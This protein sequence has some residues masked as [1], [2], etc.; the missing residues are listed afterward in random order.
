MPDNNRFDFEVDVRGTQR[1]KAEIVGL[2]EQTIAKASEA[3]RTLNQLKT[4]SIEHA[5]SV[6]RQSNAVREL[7]IVRAR[8]VQSIRDVQQA[9]TPYLQQV[10]QL[11]KGLKNTEGLLK[12]TTAERVKLQATIGADTKKIAELTSKEKLYQSTIAATKDVLGEN[13][14]ILSKLDALKAQ[15]VNNSRILSSQIVTERAALSQLTDAQQKN[16]V[17]KQKAQQTYQVFEGQVRNLKKEL[18]EYEKGQ[19]ASQRETERMTESTL[20]LANAVGYAA[21]NAFRRVIEAIKDFL[22]EATIYAARTDEMRLAMLNMSKQSGVSRGELLRQAEAMQRMNI[23]TQETYE[24]LT[25]FQLAQLDVGKATQLARVAQDLAVVAG[26]ETGEEVNRLVHGITTLQ[27]RVLRTAGVYLSL[28]QTYQEVARATGRSTESF[29]EAE[30]QQIALNKVIELGQRAAGNYETALDNAGKRMRSMTRLFQD[31]ENAVGGLLQGPFGNLVDALST[32]LSLIANYPR[33]FAAAVVVLAAFG[34]QLLKTSAAMGGMTARVFQ[35]AAGLVTATKAT[36]GLAQATTANAAAMNGAAVAGTTWRGA[37][38]NIGTQAGILI[39]LMA[40]LDLA[41]AGVAETGKLFGKTTKF[42]DV[43]DP[44]DIKVQRDALVEMRREQEELK[45]LLDERQKIGVADK[46][47]RGSG[48]IGAGQRIIDVGAKYLPLLQGAQSL[49]PSSRSTEEL[50]KRYRELTDDIEKASVAVGEQKDEMSLAAALQREYA[51][52]VGKAGRAHLDFSGTSE[53]V[54][55]RLDRMRNQLKAL[56][57]PI[58][59]ET[60][61][62]LTFTERLQVLKPELLDLDTIFQQSATS[63]EDY[64]Q[65]LANAEA[66]MP[67]FTEAVRRLRTEGEKLI[68]GVGEREAEAIRRLIDVQRRLASARREIIS[69][70]G[71]ANDPQTRQTAFLETE[72]KRLQI[73]R[74]EIDSI[75]SARINLNRDIGKPIPTS[76]E[77][78]LDLQSTY[79]T[80]IKVRD[81]IRTAQRANRDF[82]A[83]V[84]KAQ[85]IASKAR[86]TAITA[87]L[88]A[89]KMIA[90]NQTKRIQD[91]RQ[92]TAEIIALSKERAE[93]ARDEAGTSR[94]AYASFYKEQ[95]ENL[96]TLEDTN[97]RLQ[98]QLEFLGGRKI[99]GLDIPQFEN[100]STALEDIAIPTATQAENVATITQSVQNIEKSVAANNPNYVTGLGGVDAKTLAAISPGAKGAPLLSGNVADA[101]KKYGIDPNLLL[102]LAYRE[103]GISQYNDRGGVL[104]SSAGALGVMQLMP[105]T[106]K[107][108]GADPYKT[109]ENIDAGA[110]YLS[111]LIKMFNGKLNLALAGYNAGEFVKNAPGGGT[112]AQ[113]EA[114]LN[115]LLAKNED[116]QNYVKSILGYTGLEFPQTSPTLARGV[117]GTAFQQKGVETVVPLTP[118]QIMARTRLNLTI[119]ERTNRELQTQYAGSRLSDLGVAGL[120]LETGK[121]ELENYQKTADELRLINQRIAND[122]YDSETHKQQVTTAAELVRR[123]AVLVTHDVLLA[124]IDEEQ[125]QWRDSEEY[126]INIAE[127]AEAKIRQAYNNS[128]DA[129]ESALAERAKREEF[130]DKYL[131]TIHQQAETNRIRISLDAEERYD[132]MLEESNSKFRE[133]TEFKLAQWKNFEVDRFNE[134]KRAEDNIAELQY[135]IQHAT[136]LDPLVIEE[137]RLKAILEVQQAD[138]Q[139]KASMAANAVK[140]ADAQVYHADRANAKIL[141]Y[142]AQQETLDDVVANIR[143]GTIDLAFNTLDTAIGKLTAKLGIF[144]ELVKSII[145][146]FL[147]LSL[148]KVFQTLFGLQTVSAQPAQQNVGGGLG[149]II[150]NVLGGITGGRG[151]GPTGIFGT[152]PPFVP[153]ASGPFGLGGIIGPQQGTQQAL[154]QIF[155]GITGAPVPTFPATAERTGGTWGDFGRVLG[156]PG[157]GGQQRGGIFSQLGGAFGSIAPMFPFLGAALGAQLGGGSKLGSVLGTAGGALG[158][159]LGIALA[160]TSIGGLGGLAAGLAPLGIVAAVA[161]PLLIAGAIIASRNKKRRENETKRDAFTTDALGQLNQ[162]LSRVRRDQIS[163]EEALAQATSIRAQYIQQSQALTDSKTRGIALKD[164]SRLDLVIGQIKAASKAQERRRELDAQLVPEFA[165]GGLVSSGVGGVVPGRDLGYDNVLALLRP[166]EVVLNTRQQQAIGGPTAL[167]AAGVPGFV[168][169]TAIAARRYAEGGYSSPFV[170]SSFG[171]SRGKQEQDINVYIVTNKKYAE[172]M[173]EQG[174]D[175][176]IELADN[177]IRNKGRIYSAGK[178]NF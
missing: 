77:E 127:D 123:K 119:Q 116:V 7:S 154:Q 49:F 174:R 44:N 135:Q 52:Q 106:A 164:V 95:L 166:N 158:G 171:L 122:F 78:R 88:T 114:R 130:H 173:A 20:A 134:T 87:E 118:G 83:E 43:L 65:K 177:D 136:D 71:L 9:S 108:F 91:E 5:N 105:G 157:G 42:S 36:L 70:L 159:L 149:N 23:T 170:E 142:L 80:A 153:S 168:K 18:K 85:Q 10:S 66:R 15:H 22:V 124:L 11:T 121:Q 102:M 176:I 34:I 138:G 167:A 115:S 73:L 31:M 107:R 27:T 51:E 4:S 33:V 21:Y 96:F 60:G 12:A 146:G 81:E 17:A 104:T 3:S 41:M 37:L 165:R 152:T 89:A 25:K 132:V 125:Q 14:S 163:G 58:D 8:E 24:T 133:S 113:R 35:M 28:E 98:A 117:Q 155:Q 26:V 82:I 68:I 120:R 16:S 90:D 93:Q 99:P 59:K 47:G 19:A 29:S 45:K 39:A 38:L 128:K 86:E 126:R 2:L 144:D 92:M 64:E 150:Q 1:T 137:A 74:Q 162:L 75:V 84:V 160:P 63:Q 30:K 175:K 100:I 109:A 129:L 101:A 48:V 178:R 139:A 111:E 103:S 54:G 46:Y 141:D 32:L 40:A 169:S 156:F 57:E 56:E 61:L 151:S 53:I 69:L 172:E 140:L 147:K 67:G 94:R 62:I 50:S 55:F 148:S 143:I 97:R 6:G 112:I 145:T 13:R 161:A 76:R 72:E 79:E 110:K 131:Q